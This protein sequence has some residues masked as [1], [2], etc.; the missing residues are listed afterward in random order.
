MIQ[1][2]PC[3]EQIPGKGWLKLIVLCQSSTQRYHALKTR[4]ESAFGA[5]HLL[6]FMASSFPMEVA[7]GKLLFDG[8]VSHGGLRFLS[9]GGGNPGARGGGLFLFFS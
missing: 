7:T 6:Y 9:G 3:N 8:G 5:Q 2:F 4:E 1:E